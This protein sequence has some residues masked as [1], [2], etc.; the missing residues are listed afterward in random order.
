M[1][2]Q[3]YYL[4]ELISVMVMIHSIWS[5]LLLQKKISLPLKGFLRKCL[6][7]P[8]VMI[9]VLFV[10]CMEAAV[11]A[12][13]YS[14]K[15]ALPSLEDAMYFSL[16]SYATVG[17]GDVL[18]PHELRL[19]GAAEGLIGTLMVSWTMAVLVNYFKDH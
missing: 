6:R 19:T 17:Y 8:L 12:V 9:S 11:F 14:F 10:H 4:A 1:M 16:A 2:Q 5:A 15:E 18:L 13:F 7:L 3:F